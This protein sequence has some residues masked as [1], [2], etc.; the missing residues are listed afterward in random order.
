MAV[1]EIMPGVKIVNITSNVDKN[2]NTQVYG[3]GDDNIVYWWVRAKKT[4]YVF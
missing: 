1:Q 3:L 2:D 4:W